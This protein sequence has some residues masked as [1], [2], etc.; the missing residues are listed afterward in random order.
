MTIRNLDKAFAPQSVA[1][2]GGSD[3]E[4]SVGN[5]VLRNI[6]AGGYPGKVWPV[7]P[8]YR[9]VHGLPCYHRIADLPAAPDLAVIVTPSA[10]VPGLVGELAARGCR[11]ATVLTAG[12]TDD[13]G[14]RPKMLE[15]GRD[16]LFRVIGPNV[17][18]LILPHAKL[19]ASFAHM[20]A[21][22][23]GLA[24][25]SQSGAMITSIIDWAADKEIGFSALVSLGDQADVDVGDCLDFV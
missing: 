20:D 15:A 18:G 22:P 17:V 25:L 1:I 16:S 2:I 19:N 4:G 3:R 8:K 23:G 21:R 9:K 6:L 5:V 12:I 11:A 13:N 7:N 10:S 14:L 24:L